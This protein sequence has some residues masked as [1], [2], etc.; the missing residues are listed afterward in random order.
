MIVGILW[1]LDRVLN[2]LLERV[3]LANE[4]NEL[5]VTTTAAKYDQPVFF[6]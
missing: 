4:F 5:W 1:V 6:V 3:A 2:Q